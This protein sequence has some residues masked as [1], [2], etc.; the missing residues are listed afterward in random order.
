MHGRVRIVKEAK[1]WT[2]IPDPEDRYSSGIPDFDRLLGGGFQRGSLALFEMDETVGQDD[3]DLLLFPTILNLLYQSRGVIA[4]LPS[5][6]SPHDFRTRMSRF[7][8]RRR[9]DNRVRVVD[10]T[11]ED[12]G[13]AYVVSLKGMQSNPKRV[14]K[15]NWSSNPKVIQ[16][17]V[18]KMRAAE[19][20]AQGN[21]KKSYLELNAI[22]VADTLA[23]GEAA[24]RMFFF[25]VKRARSERN[26]VIGLLTPG[27]ECAA[28]I[29]RMADT[30]FA[31]HRDEVGL[32]IRGLR[33]SFPSYVVSGDHP[34]GPPHVAFV[35]RP[36]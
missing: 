9:F 19:R 16:E 36:S 7:V 29:R 1:S 17:D 35:P 26:L 3:L 22:E 34:A 4:V 21:R 18:T 2:P 14:G 33:P 24:S 13:P 10:Y 15:P 31:L 25:G 8:T 20:A 23:G 6:D 27:V 12:E 11:G 28:V 30:K 32:V 5:A